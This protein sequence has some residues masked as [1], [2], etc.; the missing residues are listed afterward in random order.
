ML[1][2]KQHK[3]M[4]LMFHAPAPEKSPVQ[5]DLE[6][7]FTH[8]D[9]SVR[10]KGFYDGGDIYKVRFLPELAGGDL[11]MPGCKADYDNILKGLEDGTLTRQQLMINA[12]RV[13]RMTNRLTKS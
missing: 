7:V 13:Y 1:P 3:M 10:V 5:I 12:T 2:M 11:F 4:E 9:C 6:T 8:A